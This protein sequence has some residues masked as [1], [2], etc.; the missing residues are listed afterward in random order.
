[1]ILLGVAL[2]ASAVLAHLAGRVAGLPWVQAVAS[3]GQLGVPVAAVTLGIQTGVLE[4]GE[5]A[6]IL[7]GALITVAVAAVATGMAA[8]PAGAHPARAERAAPRRRGD[9]AL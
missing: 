7:L 8:R 3:A 6:G 9:R 1:M 2:G 4:P 5:D